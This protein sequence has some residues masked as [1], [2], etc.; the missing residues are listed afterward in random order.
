M[1]TQL[2]DL[3]FVADI[4]NEN[5]ARLLIAGDI[6]HRPQV[7][8]KLL[9]QTYTILSEVRQ[10]VQF[11]AGNHDVPNH[12]IERMDESS[13]GVLAEL[14]GNKVISGHIANDCIA[15]GVSGFSWRYPF[16]NKMSSA[17]IVIC[18]L[19][20]VSDIPM[21]AEKTVDPNDVF[22]W[23]PRAKLI[24]AGD[25][26]KSMLYTNKETEQVLLVP[27]CLNCQASDFKDYD[28][29]VHL[30]KDEELTKIYIPQ[31]RAKYIEAADLK[32]KPKT[33]IAENLGKIGG[34][35]VLAMF[36]ANLKASKPNTAQKEYIN[37]IHQE[38]KGD[39]IW[40]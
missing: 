7:S 1:E 28:P 16:K 29:V 39:L 13:Y 14:F 31:E 6:F 26:H 38:L 24:I 22:K 8:E 30:F 40:T 21:A 17:E 33:S 37:K 9:L 23:L 11:I 34:Q 15:Q 10:G 5:N 19:T 20:I 4:A 18:H 36:Y 3:Q 27:G 12:M 25:I 35:S 2:G 32:V